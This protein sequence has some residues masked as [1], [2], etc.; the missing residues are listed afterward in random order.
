LKWIE[1][2]D[3]G[4]FSLDAF[5]KLITKRT[6]IVALTHMS[7]V[8]A[9]PT[10]IKEIARIAHAHGVPVAGRRFA[11]RG[12]S[13]CRRAALDC[14]F[15]VLTGHKL[16]GPTGVGALYGKSKWLENLPPFCGGGRDD[17]NGPRRD[18]VTYNVP[19]QRFEAGTPPDRPSGGSRRRRSIIWRALAARRFARMRPI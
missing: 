17:R 15:Y 3:D 11:G 5:E 19:P 12:A 9:A 10:P 8:V 7:N 1:V 13:R 6:K 4:N 18:S 2:D 14:D 16:Y